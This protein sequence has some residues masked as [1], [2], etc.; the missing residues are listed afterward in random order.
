MRAALLVGVCL[1]TLTSCRTRH[2]HPYG[3]STSNHRRVVHVHGRY[4]GHVRV[5]GVWV[6]KTRDRHRH[7][8]T[9]HVHG[10]HCGHERVGGIWGA[11]QG[12]ASGSQSQP[13][14]P[15]STSEPVQEQ[16]RY[17]PG[18]E[19]GLGH[20]DPTKPGGG[21][22]LG[23]ERRRQRG[24]SVKH[25]EGIEVDGEVE[26]VHVDRS[27]EKSGSTGGIAGSHPALSKP[28]PPGNNGKAKDPKSSGGHGKSDRSSQ[29]HSHGKGHETSSPQ[30]HGQKP[31]HA[32]EPAQGQKPDNGKSSDKPQR[33]DEQDGDG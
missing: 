20:T 6:I 30:G 9:Q 13:Y 32:K 8:R 31:D 14:P 15:S 4:C 18:H 10:P 5:D 28:S 27:V 29:G 24:E 23:H 17:K 2:Y 33:S 11:V 26:W 16:R 22:A 1:L 7:H 21:R 3:T 25:L 19:T 12:Q